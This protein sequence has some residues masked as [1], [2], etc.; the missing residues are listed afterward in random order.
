M[1]LDLARPADLDAIVPLMIDFNAVELIEWRPEPMTAALARLL[2]DPALG[3]VLLARADDGGALLGY[4]VATMGYDIEFGGPDAFV[5]EL[6]VDAAVRGRGVGR[7]LL[8]GLMEELSRRGAGAVQL[9]VRPEN[10]AAR[11]LYESLGFAAVPRLV[12][13][14]SLEAPRE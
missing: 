5:T 1:R 3:F 10:N 14:R 11:A 6:Y 2:A 13:A 9:M 7:A 8:S 12:L 4:G